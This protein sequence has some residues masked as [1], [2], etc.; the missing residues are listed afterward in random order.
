MSTLGFLGL[1]TM[2]REMARRLVDAGHDVIVWN[3]SA[4][5][6]APLVEAGARAAETPAEALAAPISFSMLANDE[7]ADHVL[8]ADHLAG[9]PGRLHVSMASLSPDAA[10]R[11]ARRHAEA[12]VGYLA[13]P[14]LGRF[15]VAAAGELNIIAAGAAADL[16]RVAPYFEILGKRVW[17]VGADPRIAN[18]VKAAVNYD[19]IHAFQ[20]IAESVALVEANDVDAGLFTELLSSTLFPGPVY[21]GYGAMIAERRYT[22]PGFTMALGSKDLGLAEAIAA[23]AGIV[24]PSAPVLRRAF[25][26]ALASEDL[27]DVDWSGVAEI[28]RTGRYPTE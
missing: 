2:G 15:T 8:S 23:E 12:G 22:P 3:R 19:I 25:D 28:T 4:D 18:V 9:E 11:L 17:T 16:E 6:V 7:A 1:G 21:T 24:L 14:V 10:S 27:K 20:A 13:A 26:T 5:A